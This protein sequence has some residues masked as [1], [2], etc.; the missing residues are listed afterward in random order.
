MQLG[1]TVLIVSGGGADLE[2]GRVL[3]DAG[4]TVRLA[5]SCADAR[6]VVA[7]CNVPC[8]L[9]SDVSLPDGTWVDILSLANEGERNIPVIVLSRVVDIALYISALESG[10]C[11]FVVPPYYHQDTAHI[12]KCVASEGLAV[13]SVAA[14]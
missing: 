7:N 3:T 6:E 9:F 5:K 11:D 14:A 1:N 12:L 10:A 2:L 13:Q 8:V 4:V